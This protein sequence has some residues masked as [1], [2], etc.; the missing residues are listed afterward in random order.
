M[1]RQ[2]VTWHNLHTQHGS[3]SWALIDGMVTVRSAEGTKSAYLG[4]LPPESLVRL[5]LR[6]LSEDRV[7]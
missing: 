6:E 3:G 2:F 1:T 5:M 4:C 7:A